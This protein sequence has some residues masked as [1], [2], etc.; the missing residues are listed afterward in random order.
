YYTAVVDRYFLRFPE[1]GKF[2]IK[3][4]DYR[5]GFYRQQEYY[6][7]FWGRSIGNVVD[8]VGLSAPEVSVRVLALPERG[9]P[10]DFSGA[11]GDFE[12]AAEFPD[13]E[14]KNGE[15]TLLTVTISGVGSLEGVLLPNIPAMLPEGLQFKSMTDNVSHYIKDGELGSEVEIECIVMPKREGKFVIDSLRFSFYNSFT[16]KYDT[17]TASSLEIEAGSGLPSSGRPPVIMEI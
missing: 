2:R 4:A 14:I 13:G 6:D 10:D 17:I 15:D 11:V 1:K 9:R 5:L 7:P 12:I 3:G 16:G 8:A